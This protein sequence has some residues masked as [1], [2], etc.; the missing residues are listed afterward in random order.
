MLFDECLLA[1]KAEQSAASEAEIEFEYDD[2]DELAHELNEMYSYSESLEFFE[3][4]QAFHD[5][6]SCRRFSGWQQSARPQR[7]CLVEAMLDQLE[8]S[9]ADVRLKALQALAYILQGCFMD[10][11]TEEALLESISSNAFLCYDCG[12]WSLLCMVL[13]MEIDQ[14]WDIAC[15]LPPRSLRVFSGSKVT[16]DSLKDSHVLRLTLACMYTIV[17]CVR[18]FECN[19]E[20]SDNSDDTLS[21]E[22][23]LRTEVKRSLLN[24]L[25]DATSSLNVVPVLFDMLSRFCAGLVPHYPIRK[26]LLLLWKCL[27]A[28]LGGWRALHN[29]K[30]DKRQAFGL[31]PCEDTIEI[32]STMQPI[33]N[34]TFKLSCDREPGGDN[35]NNGNGEFP[36][37]VSMIVADLVSDDGALTDASDQRPSSPFPKENKPSNVQAVKDACKNANQQQ[38][39]LPW[40]S[41]VT[42]KAVENFL[43][44]KRMKFFGYSFGEGDRVTTVGLPKPIQESY[45]AQVRHVYVSLSEMQIARER[46]IQMYPMTH[47]DDVESDGPSERLYQ[48]ILPNMRK[49][50]FGLVKVLLASAPCSKGKAD[51]VN[52]VYE[53]LPYSDDVES[54]TSLVDTPEALR[55]NA[56][57]IR[58]KEIIAKC[59]SAMLL[60]ILKHLKVNHI[61]QFEQICQQLVFANCIPLILKYFDQNVSYD[62]GESATGR[63]YVWRNLFSLVNLL[64]ILNKLTK[65][66]HGRTMMLVVY[67]SAPILKRT[68]RVKQALLQ[69]FALKLL[70]SQAKYLG[71]QWRRSNME[72]LSAIYRNRVP[73]IDS[74]D[75]KA[76]ILKLSVCRF[77]HFSLSA[78]FVFLFRIASRLSSLGCF[79]HFSMLLSHCFFIFAF[80]FFFFLSSFFLSFLC[81]IY[82]AVLSISVCSNYFF[83]FFPGYCI[84]SVECATIIPR[85]NICPNLTYVH[86]LIAVVC[87]IVSDI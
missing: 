81:S 14:S 80:I 19:K 42:F 18:R 72:L 7:C 60:L 54:A 78:Q 56:D 68:L 66:K 46:L 38:K 61:Y 63:P 6:C 44:M 36:V 15:S 16:S 5:F 34:L 75:F 86:S 2:C 9:V 76:G 84:S 51:M 82:I 50:T 22:D 24:E 79:E 59:V 49:L 28:V 62:T 69:L 83:F 20:R 57:V 13:Q 64:R 55:L 31:Q 21:E 43:E 41:K 52:I 37:D 10:H 11:D 33:S 53:V 32:A 74:E 70:K 12:A 29:L 8:S 71:R 35:N 85:H 77:S 73:S 39:R 58:Q 48:M 26:V 25:D 27:L 3:N 47:K 87:H 45:N 30:N 4:Y 17:E 65:W 1:L 40:S 67:K 23:V